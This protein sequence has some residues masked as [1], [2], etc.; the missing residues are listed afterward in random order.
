MS[1]PE[2][3]R[4]LLVDDRRENLLALE[5]VL[6]TLPCE[7]V[8]VTSGEAALKQ[9]LHGEFA[10]ALLDVQM[11]ELD[12][13]E[14]AELIKSRERTRALPIIFVTA[15]S[16]ERHH[17]F[18]G[19]SAGAVDYVLKPYDPGILR[20]K[21]SVFLELHA[22][23]QAA[24]RSEALLQA[25][26][27]H[28]P[29]G[30]ARMDLD[31]RLAGAN[32]AL[33]HLLDRTAAELQGRM[34][35]SLLHP[36]DAAPQAVWRGALGADGLDGLPHELR[37]LGEASQEI[38][39]EVRFSLAR[40]EGQAPDTLVV[41]VQDLRERLRADEEREQLIREQAARAQA[42]QVS[43]RLHAVQTITDAVLDLAGFDDLIG[44]VLRRTA[45]VLAV[46]AAAAV[47]FEA[48]S[49]PAVYQVAGGVESGMQRRRGASS[50]DRL[51]GEAVKSRLAVPLV[52]AG[53]SIGELH[54]GTLFARNFSAEDTAVLGLAADRVAAAIERARLYER[55]HVIAQELQQSLLPDQ[56]PML[57]GVTTAARYRP[58]GAGSE[59]GGDWYD[60]IV[61]PGGTLLLVIGDVA[62]R[63]L[64]A[65][66]TMG[67]LRSALRAYAFDGHPPGALLDRLNAFHNGLP[68]AGMATVAL[69]AVDLGG[70]R[71]RYASAGHPPGLLVTADGAS[72]WL[73]AAL[74]V[75]LGTID[76]ASYPEAEATLGPGATL[77]LYT[78]GLVEIR[79]EHLDLGFGRLEAAAAGGPQEPESLCDAILAN[80]LADPD[81]G[82]DVTLLVLQ[83]MAAGQPRVAIE[84]PASPWALSAMRAAAH[85]WLAHASTDE[86]EI[87][88]IVLALNEAVENAIEHGQRGRGRAIELVLERAG[89][90]LDITIHDE[91]RWRERNKGD[92]GRGLT[93]MRATMDD[94]AVDSGPD[95]TTVRLR[96]R[97]RSP[98]ATDPAVPV[99]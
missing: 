6:E 29:I 22:K 96:R 32:W 75:P 26:F 87:Y 40:A 17:I 63:G 21:V 54:V 74:G 71:V 24:A 33:A 49:D 3:P 34:F 92:R 46:D 38:P 31:G 50:T 78:D 9:L 65:A 68:G 61:Q 4:V 42:E 94:V 11:P 57:P 8:S 58:A 88:E 52:V 53:R 15:I 86:T 19:Y 51:L 97:L 77:V 18:R 72:H 41:Q 13:F 62:G 98:V 95:G 66:A 56:L 93:M 14:T 36:D 2:L 35:D 85:R 59:V 10:V 80:T 25:A 47:L 73:D 67:Q 45:D 84:V 30:L 44:G 76:D 20:S 99:S 60:A 55:E 1:A 64:A 81:I 69:V 37:L 70:E 90:Q 12:G 39:C 27:D 16:K 23:S 89:D 83:T 91:G 28:A 79:G 82:D 7:L 43:Q 5:A 48:G